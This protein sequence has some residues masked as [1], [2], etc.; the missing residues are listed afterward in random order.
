MK[1]TGATKE[2]HKQSFNHLM[3]SYNQSFD[4]TLNGIDSE[5]VPVF[6]SYLTLVI[7]LIS[8]VIVITPSLMVI[9]V[10]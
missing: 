1:T 7:G 9:N 5:E 6:A 10:I 8:A 3:E 4:Q 2:H